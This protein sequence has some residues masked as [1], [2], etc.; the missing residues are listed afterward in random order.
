MSRRCAVTALLI[1][2]PMCINEAKA[3]STP[4][5]ARGLCAIRGA[6]RQ[7]LKSRSVAFHKPE[8]CAHHDQHLK[9]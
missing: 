8:S 7:Q 3:F 4:E 6:R 9:F 5:T 1:L 2:A